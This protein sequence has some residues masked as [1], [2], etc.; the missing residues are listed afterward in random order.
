MFDGAGSQAACEHHLLSKFILD[1]FFLVSCP[2]VSFWRHTHLFLSGVMPTCFFLVSCPIVTF[3]CHAQLFL[4]SGVLTCFFLVSLNCEDDHRMINLLETFWKMDSINPL[5]FK[6]VQSG[7]NFA[8]YLKIN[9][10][11]LIGTNNW[12]N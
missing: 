9:K 10:Y 6:F 1:C 11:L 5:K 2:I 3:W 7:S 8:V 4:S 12:G